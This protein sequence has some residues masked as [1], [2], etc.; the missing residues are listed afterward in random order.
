MREFRD[1]LESQQKKIRKNSEKNSQQIQKNFQPIQLKAEGHQK[2]IYLSPTKPAN[3]PKLNLIETPRD[4]VIKKKN[5]EMP[6]EFFSSSSSS[7][8]SENSPFQEKIDKSEPKEEPPRLPFEP[9]NPNE[10]KLGYCI[11]FIRNDG[12]LSQGLVAFSG[13]IPGKPELMFGVK[14]KQ[15]GIGQYFL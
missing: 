12:R 11:K 15:R 6:Q 1:D 3:V 9:T 7:T 13:S 8:I 5:F 10:I 2:P 14:L 4:E